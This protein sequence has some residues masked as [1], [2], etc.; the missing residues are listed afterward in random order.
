VGVPSTIL[1]SAPEKSKDPVL[2]L[3]PVHQ[4][5]EILIE[6]PDGYPRKIE[7][8]R[9]LVDGAVAAENNQDPFNRF[10]WDLTG[11]TE[12]KKHS[13]QAEI[14]DELGFTQTS[15][16]LPVDVRVDL[17]N[18][19]AWMEFLAAGGVYP[20]L[21]VVFVLGVLAAIGITNLRETGTIFPRTKRKPQSGKFI[22]SNQEKDVENPEDQLI[23]LEKPEPAF[24]AF[25]QLLGKNMKPVGDPP[26]LLDKGHIHFG[27]DRQ[28]AT[29][30]IEDDTLEGLHCTIGLR[31]D[32]S[33]TITDHHSVLGTWVN[34]TAIST[35]SV[36]LQHGDVI[37]VG[38][39]AYRYQENPPRRTGTVEVK[40][41]QS[42]E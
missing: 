17:P 30:W 1:R 18:Q 19:T 28:K 26:I 15:A 31:E 13:L 39:M 32:G 35:E 21:A 4:I 6:Y 12:S 42:G 41:Y 40:P 33:Y 20:L 29:I 38:D 16:V 3:A 5:L 34:F 2:E 14:T 22:G 25:L 11:Y 37:Q 10:T 9:L 7:A 36:L 23:S 8:S 24:Q 27:S